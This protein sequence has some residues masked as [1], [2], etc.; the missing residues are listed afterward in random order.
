MTDRPFK[1]MARSPWATVAQA[2][3]MTSILAYNFY[4][5]QSVH[6]LLL[7]SIWIG[8][9]FMIFANAADFQRMKK[10]AGFEPPYP[11]FNFLLAAFGIGF[12]GFIFSAISYRTMAMFAGGLTI[13]GYEIAS[14]TVYSMVRPLYVPFSTASERAMFGFVAGSPMLIMQVWVGFTEELQ[15]LFHFK[16]LTNW[17]HTSGI[18]IDAASLSAFIG[19]NAIFGLMHYFAYHGSWVQMAM[20]I[21]FGM[22][23]WA[24]YFIPDYTNILTPEHPMEW[25]GVLLTGSVASHA[26]WN[27]LTVA[28]LPLSFIQF[29]L[30][31]VVLMT[32]SLLFM[33]LISRGNFNVAKI[34][35]K[36]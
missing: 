8:F 25:Q 1:E 15:K 28:G 33:F 4:T 31:C 29:T 14:G 22:V 2:V 5:E 16:N 7:Y 10:L 27:Y 21:L 6:P 20:A 3:A 23:F 32:V 11:F 36:D 12:G 30:L 9:L 24:S 26:T 19:A 17:L 34:T 18:S 35:F 13:F